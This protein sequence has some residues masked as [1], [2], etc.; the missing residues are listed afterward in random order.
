MSNVN[1]KLRVSLYLILAAG[2]AVMVTYGI[3]SQ[4]VYDAVAPVVAGALM[5]V[6]GGVAT[7]NTSVKPASASPSVL[8][9]ARMGQAAIPA[10]LDEVHRDR[11]TT[12]SGPSSV[13][14]VTPSSSGLPVWDQPTS[15]PD[16][17]Y[18]GRHRLDG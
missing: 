1:P 10:L 17:G 16:E 15:I 5:V 12:Y 3:I 7:A 18:T 4:D 8:E 2:G 14:A 6:G 11:S 9:W 13:P